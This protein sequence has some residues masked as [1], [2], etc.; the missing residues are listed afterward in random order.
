M[1]RTRLL[2]AATIVLMAGAAPAAFAQQFG[3]GGQ[4][5]FNSGGFG[6]SGFGQSGFGQSSFGQSGFGQSGFG[7]SGLGSSGFGGGGFGTSG[8]S[9]QGFGQSQYGNNAQGGQAFVGRDS[10]DM[11]AVFNQLGQ[12]SNQFFQQL[13][14][15]MGR[16]RRN[17]AQQENV[18][19]PIRVQ[20]HVA[21]DHVRPQPAALATTVRSRLDTLLTRRNIVAPDV[22]VVGDTVILR[23]TAPNESQRLVI[24]KLVALE[25]GV[26]AVENQMTVEELP[27]NLDSLPEVPIPPQE[28]K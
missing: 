2:T 20:L 12:S 15:T 19:R 8:F 10:S 3:M 7:Q 17:S 21:F 1:S 27:S 14:R 4:S 28:N 5:G 16:G 13:N 23:G 11:Q 22:E 6:Q 24:E 26:A 9:G 18:K 25:P